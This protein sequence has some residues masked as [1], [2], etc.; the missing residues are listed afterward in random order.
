MDTL[1]VGPSLMAQQ[2]NNPPALQETQEIQVRS[3]G[4]EDP[5]EEET[6]I[7]SGCLESSM[8]RGA[9]R[10]TIQRVTESWAQLS[11]KHPRNGFIFLGVHLE[12]PS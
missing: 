12:V 5:L 4:Q 10:G 11:T 8:D 9:W 6:A 3:L 2:V 7:H 1:Y